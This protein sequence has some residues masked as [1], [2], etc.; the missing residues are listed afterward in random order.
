MIGYQQ[1]LAQ[2]RLS[3]AVRNLANRSVFLSATSFAMALRSARKLRR[4]LFH[5]AALGGVSVFG[6]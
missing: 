3:A 6:Q 5:D 1:S 4:L 2:N